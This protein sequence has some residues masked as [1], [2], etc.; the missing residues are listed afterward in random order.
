MALRKH[1][2]GGI[3]LRAGQVPYERVI[4]LEVENADEL[5]DRATYSLIIEVMGRRSNIIL[6][7]AGMKML[8]IAKPTP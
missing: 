5:F 2:T 6:C 1:L 7:D 3:I 4:F 8:A